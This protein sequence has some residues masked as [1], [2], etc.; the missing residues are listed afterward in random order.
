MKIFDNFAATQKPME[1]KLRSLKGIS[2]YPKIHNN[3]PPPKSICTLIQIKRKNE[4]E[5]R[6]ATG[7]NIYAGAPRAP[8]AGS[9]ACVSGFV[10]VFT[11][12]LN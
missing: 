3:N 4:N 1:I 7:E 8:R 2:K 11:F 5:T 12:N 6:N 10:F 9:P